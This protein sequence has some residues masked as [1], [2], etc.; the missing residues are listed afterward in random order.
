MSIL[1]TILRGY[2]KIEPINKWLNLLKQARIVQQPPKSFFPWLLFFKVDFKKPGFIRTFEKVI[3]CMRQMP[4]GN[5][6]HVQNP[7]ADSFVRISPVEH[8]AV[9]WLDITEFLFPV[10]SNPAVFGCFA[11]GIDFVKPLV[12]KRCM[13]IS[14]CSLP[15]LANT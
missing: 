4:P 1:F 14:H 11:A 2:L 5:F 13:Y 9:P 6:A 3:F 7:A 8:Y 15:V 12:R 10:G